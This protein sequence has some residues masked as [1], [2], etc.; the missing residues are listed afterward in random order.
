MGINPWDW[1]YS[2]LPNTYWLILLPF[3]LYLPMFSG[4]ASMQFSEAWRS[5]REVSCAKSLGNPSSLFLVT[6]STVRLWRRQIVWGRE[7]TPCDF[8]V[9]ASQEELPF[10]NNLLN[11]EGP[12]NCRTLACFKISLFM[13]S[14]LREIDA[15]VPPHAFWIVAYSILISLHWRRGN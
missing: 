9:W 10:G 11:Y 12:Q 5:E 2:R 1:E 15:V 14:I 3:I 6:S 4:R 8:R 13:N 7:E